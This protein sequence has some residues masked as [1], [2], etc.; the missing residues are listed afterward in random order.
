MKL[1]ELRTLLKDFPDTAEV[2]FADPN[3]GGV[4]DN[5]DVYSLTLYEDHSRVLI[6]PPFCNPVD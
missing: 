4:G 2:D 3:F 1:G 5:L 6:R